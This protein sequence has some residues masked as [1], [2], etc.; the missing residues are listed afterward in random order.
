ME[1]GQLR[2]Q[3]SHRALDGLER[4]MAMSLIQFASSDLEEA[5]EKQTWQPWAQVKESKEDS[6]L[7]LGAQ[8]LDSREGFWVLETGEGEKEK[9][10]L[11]GETVGAVGCFWKP[12]LASLSQPN[13]PRPG[14]PHLREQTCIC[15]D[16]PGLCWAGWWWS[17]G[18]CGVFVPKESQRCEVALAPQHG[19]AWAAL[20]RQL[21]TQALQCQPWCTCAD[22]GSVPKAGKAGGRLGVACVR[23]GGRAPFKPGFT[24]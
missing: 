17:R 22:L 14:Q 15:L 24:L 21:R 18:A 12:L 1:L 2:E 16:D 4:K 5:E 13:C 6:H 11:L 7:R 8:A 10:Q 3:D 9:K 19:E 23:P 20:M